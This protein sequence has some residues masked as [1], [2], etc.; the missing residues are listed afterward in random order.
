M[1][2]QASYTDPQSKVTLPTAYVR[3]LAIVIDAVATTIEVRLGIYATAAARTIG[4]T[5]L[6]SYSAW[7]PFSAIMNGPVDIPVASYAYVKTLPVF[8]GAVDVL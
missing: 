1:A 4:G 6:L 8:T 7:P 5:P 2:L 3:I